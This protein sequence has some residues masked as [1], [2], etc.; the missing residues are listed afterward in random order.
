MVQCSWLVWLG[1]EAGYSIL[2]WHES[3]SI[4][5]EVIHDVEEVDS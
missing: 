2:L 1:D 4:V 5:V 3:L